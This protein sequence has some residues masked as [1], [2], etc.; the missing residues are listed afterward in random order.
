M[1][2]T[3]QYDQKPGDAPLPAVLQQAIDAH[4][5]GDLAAAAP[6][7]RQFLAQNVEHPLALQLLG[8]LHSQCGEYGKAIELMRESLRLFPEQAE[9][10]NNLGNALAASDSIDAA[11]KHYMD[12]I[13]IAP[14]YAEAW[15]NLGIALTRTEELNEAAA[16]FAESLK[17]RPEDATT[18]LGLGNVYRQQNNP[19]KAADCYEKA[20]RINPDFAEAHH[21]MGLALRG[22]QRPRDALDHFQ[23]SINL[24]L[25]RTELYQ[26]IAATHVDAGNID[27][28]M[29]AYRQAIHRDPEDLTSH[30]N[31]NSLLWQEQQLADH[32]VSY[33]QAIKLRPE[34]EILLRAYAIALNQ[35]GNY[36]H[37][38]SAIRDGL[39]RF[40]GSGELTSQL[41]YTLECQDRWDEALQAHAAAVTLPGSTANHKIS[42]ARALLACK[43]PDEALPQAEAGV[44]ETPFD[45]RAIAYLGLC[46]R[47]LGDPQ[48]AILNDYNQFVQAYDISLHGSY[49]DIPAF[50]RQ[51]S[52]VLIARH[53][54]KHHPPEQTLRGGTQTHGNLFNAR[55]QEIQD[56]VAGLQQCV[57]EYIQD[58]PPGPSHPLLMR[59][60]ER[61]RFSASWS[62]RLRSEGYHTMHVH[63]LGWI[64]SAY[65][66]EL[67]EDMAA[68]D[69]RAG[70]IKFGEPDI[71][72]GE[73]GTPRR[74]IQ[75]AVGKLVLFPSYMWHGTVPFQSAH[76]RM[77]VAFD[78]VPVHTLPKK[79]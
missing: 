2:I 59:R 49:D 32:L 69:P 24:G 58:M 42:Y 23:T 7:Y 19:D 77:T 44:K 53:H 10:L 31:L 25:D 63:P 50:N 30:R 61:F 13:R 16:A 20:L 78:V 70:F 18:W 68:S 67:P 34:S 38:E 28:A 39:R 8:L 29:Q 55:E 71:D 52:Q 54:G 14:G 66:V 17:I 12:A 47:M 21:N 76:P 43:R 64:S 45:Q 36:T 75:P 74:Y 15:K 5:A 60:G 4:R 79:A 6:L 48:D 72:I 57:R 22:M 3:I 51:L 40:P 65:Y 46:W 41:A 35:A 27:A 9:V 56:L 11:K 1:S 26:N 62:V 73:F 37:A 33:R